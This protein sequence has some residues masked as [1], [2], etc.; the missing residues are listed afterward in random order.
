MRSSYEL[1]KTGDE[2]LNKIGVEKLIK[3]QA[4]SGNSEIK[5]K[6]IGIN[7]E[8]FTASSE[9]FNFSITIKTLPKKVQSAARRI[10]DK[11]NDQLA[12]GVLKFKRSRLDRVEELKNNRL[13]GAYGRLRQ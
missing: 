8:K 3:P 11:V 2:G 10:I 5:L 6:G 7:G 9:N 4:E 1:K 12:I 13:K